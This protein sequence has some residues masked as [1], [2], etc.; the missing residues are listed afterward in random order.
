MKA[1]FV[2]HFYHN[3]TK[4]SEFMVN[5]LRQYFEVDIFWANSE[6]EYLEEIADIK[7]LDYDF[8]VLWQI[9]WLAPYFL[10]HGMKTIV[11]P[12]FDGSSEMKSQHWKIASGALFINFS[13][14]LH[15]VIANAGGESIYVKYF[16]GNYISS[17]F[18]CSHVKYLEKPTAFF[19][20]RRPDT[21]I[22]TNEICRL[23]NGVISHLHIHQ[24]PDP[25]L[26]PSSIPSKLNFSISTSNW[27]QNSE[28]YIDCVCSHDI[29]VAPRYAEGIGM[30]FLEAMSLGRVVLAHDAPTHNE[31][32]KN[33]QTGILFNAFRGDSLALS[34]DDIKKIKYNAFSAA[35]AMHDSWKNFYEPLIIRKISFYIKSS[36]IPRKNYLMSNISDYDFVRNL[37]L[38]HVNSVDYYEFIDQLLSK[39]DNFFKK[40]AHAIMAEVNFFENKGQTSV[41][42]DLLKD[43]IKESEEDAPYKLILEMLLIRMR[44]KNGKK[45]GFS[46]V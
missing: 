17:N 41:A 46:V 20:E 39:K 25:G 22:N 45:M 24:A 34:F 27:F 32:I 35:R 26:N 44:L 8:V 23:L 21:H 33:Y 29:Y 6:D 42:V 12:M 10:R 19:W 40:S 2:D 9:D 15:T 5:L 18:D 28:E 7:N 43:R 16:P 37:M 31:Y 11:I 36:F 30:G 13:L 1:L 14:S 4:S 3:T 38:A